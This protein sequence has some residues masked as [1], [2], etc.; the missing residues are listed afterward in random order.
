MLKTKK[1]ILIIKDKKEK[2]NYVQQY[3][4]K[5]NSSNNNNIN[6]LN[7]SNRKEKENNLEMSGYPKKS[8]LIDYNYLFSIYNKMNN[9]I[10]DDISSLTINHRKVNPRHQSI[11]N[12]YLQTTV[13]KDDITFRRNDDLDD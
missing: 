1:I 8:D 3:H 12:N 4:K 2:I 13:K 11:D 6:Y 10:D 7:Y 5:L 9:N